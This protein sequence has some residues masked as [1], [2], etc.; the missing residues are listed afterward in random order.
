[1]LPRTAAHYEHQQ[2]PPI[3]GVDQ[4]L[5]SDLKDSAKVGKDCDRYSD[6]DDRLEHLRIPVSFSES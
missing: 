3:A 4:T 2:S 1:M 5:R 6:N